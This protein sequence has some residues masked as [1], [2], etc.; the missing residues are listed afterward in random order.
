LTNAAAAGATRI[1]AS[2]SVSIESI[3]ANLKL[4]VTEVAGLLGVSRQAVYKWLSGSVPDPDKL[5]RLETLSQI[6]LE[7]AAAGVVKPQ[8][9]LDMRLFDGKSLSDLIRE[10]EVQPQHIAAAALEAVARQTSYSSSGLSQSTTA[11]RDAWTTSES[12]ASAG[13]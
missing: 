7:F 11:P 9:A 5:L 2:P 1:I 10:D 6:G 13:E 4:T 3:R 8:A 12:L